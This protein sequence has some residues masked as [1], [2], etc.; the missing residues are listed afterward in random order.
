VVIWMGI[1]VLAL[2]LVLGGWVW[3]GH[4][5]SEP[6]VPMDL[7][8]PSEADRERIVDLCV[9]LALELSRVD[10]AIVDSE[11]KAIEDQLMRGLDDRTREEAEEIVR[12]VL[13]RTISVDQD[14]GAVDEISRLADLAHRRFLVEM[15][16]AVAMADGEVN[17][18]ER[19]FAEPIASRLGVPFEV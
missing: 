15:L 11:I 17:V 6:P 9:Y 1:G 16:T 19:T 14:S 18:D 13:K 7:P 5:G 2:A 3:F 10:G 8:T 12:R 4:R